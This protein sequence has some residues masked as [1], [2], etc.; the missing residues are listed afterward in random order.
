MN[1]TFGI[2]TSCY[3]GYDR[4]L[5]EWSSSILSMKKLPNKV[6]IVQSGNIY[7]KNNF[8][9]IE[10]LFYR[11]DIDLKINFIK[12]HKGMGYARNKAVEITQVDRIMYLDIDDIICPEAIIYSEKYLRYDVICGGLRIIGINGKVN[13][14]L[15][16]A[17]N[18]K[19]LK[20]S[21]CC[22]SHAIYKRKFW[23]MSPYIEIND[24]LDF[25]FWLGL[26]QNGASFIGT[27]EIF[28]LYKRRKDGHH[29]TMTKQDIEK[30]KIQKK[31]FIKYGV[32][33]KCLKI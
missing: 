14:K 16:K 24:F 26:A 11:K 32:N 30:M 9:K 12:N 4:F 19:A 13:D 6:S 23:K 8:T 15:F 18:K 2:V 3:N 21:W 5:K 31:K 33:S 17:S 22:C 7:D 29:L 10:R 27:R 20:G 25:P 1:E 28:T